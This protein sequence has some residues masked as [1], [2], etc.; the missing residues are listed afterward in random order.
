MAFPPEAVDSPHSLKQSFLVS[1]LSLNERKGFTERNHMNTH[2]TTNNIEC[3]QHLCFCS[4]FF[5]NKFQFN[6]SIYLYLYYQIF[7]W[8]LYH[9]FSTNWTFLVLWINQAMT[10]GLRDVIREDKVLYGLWCALCEV[11][12]FELGVISGIKYIRMEDKTSE[13]C[14]FEGHW[15]TFHSEL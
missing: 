2:S 6:K 8:R 12:V 1:V 7:D 9:G 11:A 5:A 14:S 15:K 4:D 13:D 10:S 3:T